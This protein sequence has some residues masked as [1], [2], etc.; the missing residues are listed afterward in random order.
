MSSPFWCSSFSSAAHFSSALYNRRSSIGI[1]KVSSNRPARS[2]KTEPGLYFWAQTSAKKVAYISTKS[3]TKS[4]SQDLLECTASF[5]HSGRL[6]DLSGVVTYII[7]SCALL[8]FPPK[9]YDLHVSDQSYALPRN[10]LHVF[11]QSHAFSRNILLS[12][13]CTIILDPNYYHLTAKI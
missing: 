2:C 7:Q 4:R 12:V 8:A 5:L 13:A 6:T 1:F 10:N 9:H 3:S 11:D